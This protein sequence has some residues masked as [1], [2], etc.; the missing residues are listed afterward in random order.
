MN[1]ILKIAY[2]L[3]KLAITDVSTVDLRKALSPVLQEW[4]LQVT[5]PTRRKMTTEQGAAIAE[6]ASLGKQLVDIAPKMSQINLN[7][8]NIIITI[9]NALQGK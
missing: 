6:I 5:D 8:K 7:L 1:N 3:E 9:G 4:A 2:E